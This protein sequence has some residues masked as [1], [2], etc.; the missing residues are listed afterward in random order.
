[1]YQI[2]N[3]KREDKKL[4]VLSETIDGTEEILMEIDDPCS[5]YTDDSIISAGL[6]IFAGLI[7]LKSKP[8][9]SEK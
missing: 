2:K 8:E 7:S 3:E 1:M 5:T 4:F 6:A 9:G